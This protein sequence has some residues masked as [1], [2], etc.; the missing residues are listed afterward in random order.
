M[1]D[2]ASSPADGAQASA[3][4]DAL[5]EA[6]LEGPRGDSPAQAA[7]DS[8]RPDPAHGRSRYRFLCALG[9]GPIT[10]T[11]DDDPSGIAAYSQ[12]GAQ[13]GFSI[14]WTTLFSY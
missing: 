4:P 5:R 14:A 2:T 6:R 8:E 3:L 9:A 12:A 13:F 7:P 1:S 10:G 11:A